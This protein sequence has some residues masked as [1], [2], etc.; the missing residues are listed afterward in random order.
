LLRVGEVFQDFGGVA[1]GFDGGPDGFDFAGL[2]D[3]ERAADDAHEFASHELLLLPRTVGFDG[4]VVGI[5]QQR[6][7]EFVLGLEQR[8]GFDRISAHAKDGHFAL[9]KL[10]FCVAKLGRLDG[11]TGSVGLGEE[12]EQDLLALVIFERDGFVFVGLEAERVS[13]VAGL[14]H[15]SE[16]PKVYQVV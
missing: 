10:L 12:E 4:F 16:F 14:E 9:I 7:I 2:A 15:G 3:E 1:F 11:S 13:F 5:A 8:L 6:K